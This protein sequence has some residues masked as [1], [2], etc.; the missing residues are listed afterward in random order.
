MRIDSLAV[1]AL[2]VAVVVLT[3][4]SIAT[5]ATETVAGPRPLAAVGL[6][7]AVVLAASAIG[8]RSTNRSSNPYW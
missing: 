3:V 5:L 2:L 1:A 8:A 4:G 7:A 6:L